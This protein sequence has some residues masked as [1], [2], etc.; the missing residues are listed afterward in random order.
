MRHGFLLHASDAV[1]VLQLSAAGLDGCVLHGFVR[2]PHTTPLPAV[3]KVLP[4]HAGGVGCLEGLFVS[5]PLLPL[6]SPSPP[7]QFM[8]TSLSLAV[9]D[10]CRAALKTAKIF[11]KEGVALFCTTGALAAVQKVLLL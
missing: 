9:V 7:L 4:L 1:P 6:F 10:D 5:Q 8:V 3:L 11:S 2:L